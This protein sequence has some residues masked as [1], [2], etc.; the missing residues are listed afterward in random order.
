MLSR[1]HSVGIA[2]RA[3]DVS[4][5]SSISYDRSSGSI[6]HRMK[7]SLKSRSG[8]LRRTVSESGAGHDEFGL[9]EPFPDNN[10][11]RRDMVHT[12]Y[13]DAAGSFGDLRKRV[14]LPSKK[15]AFMDR[16]RESEES[17]GWEDGPSPQER[18]KSQDIVS[19]WL[20]TS[21]EAEIPPTS[22]ADLSFGV[23][24]EETS[25]V[26]GPGYNDG[27]PFPARRQSLRML[28]SISEDE[29]PDFVGSVVSTAPSTPMVPPTIPSRSRSPPLRRRSLDG[30]ED[31]PRLRGL[32]TIQESVP[33]PEPK[34]HTAPRRSLD[35]VRP[36]A[37]ES[38][39]EIDSSS[40]L[41][42]NKRR[43]GLKAFGLPRSE[44]APTIPTIPTTSRPSPPP[45]SRKASAGLMMTPRTK[46]P[47]MSSLSE[48]GGLSS[49]GTPVS[50]FQRSSNNLM[51]PREPQGRHSPQFQRKPLSPPIYSPGSVSIRSDRIQDE[52]SKRLT[53]IAYLT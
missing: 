23:P 12:P 38:I 36:M 22:S 52:E 17:L 27:V 19:A 11:S 43:L 8:R 1:N 53:E 51:G 37:L 9:D 21:G 29:V 5:D 33:T 31:Y 4:E 45:P 42:S 25:E 47:W 44:S 16:Y 2:G 7:T 14:P 35:S 15:S 6:V 39:P 20:D 28:D 26:E 41:A 18:Q 50:P 46:G 49:P 40:P 24:E 10:I 32:D 3:S 30:Q 48:N 34:S 13:P